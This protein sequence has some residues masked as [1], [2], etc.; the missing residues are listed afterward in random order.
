MQ[1]RLASAALLAG[2]ASPA[3]AACDVGI[4]T[5]GVLAPTG[6]GAVLSSEAGIASVVA[7]SN[8]TGLINSTIT[9][10]NPRLDSWPAGFAAGSATVEENYSA[11]WV[12]GSS[13]NPGF[14]AG[15]RSFVVPLGL[16]ITITINNRVTAP[17]GLKQGSYT[18]KT[19]I[20]CT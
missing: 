13:A 14:T 2:L 17:G 8:I 5:P 6:N 18:T 16:L 12:L 19:T 15:P 10:S 9:I 1:L 11:V 3:V 20:E 4:S 7:I